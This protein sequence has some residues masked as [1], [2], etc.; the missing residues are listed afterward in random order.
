MTSLNKA[1]CPRQFVLIV[2][3]VG[4]V[5]FGAAAV[6]FALSFFIPAIGAAG[7]AHEDDRFRWHLEAGP[8]LWLNN[9]VT[10]GA[11]ASA[12][13][14]T[15]AKSE[16][17]YDDGYNR[18]DASGNL[19]DGTA[20][21]LASRTGYFGYASDKQVDLKAGTLALHL[22]R[23]SAGEY[24]TEKTSQ[25]QPAWHAN[26]RVSMRREEPT[27]REWGL[28]LGIDMSELKQKSSSAIDTN[29]QVLTDTY[30]LGGVV[31]QRAP[32]SGRFSPLPGDQRIG[33][34]AT[35]TFSNVTGTVTGQ[36]EF[37]ART[38]AL[39][40]G[41][42][43]EFGKALSGDDLPELQRWALGLRGGLALISTRAD[44]KVTEQVQAPGL[45]IGSASSATARRSRTDLGT[46][47]GATVRRAFTR[48]LALV[49]G[50]EFIRGG[51]LTLTQGNNFVR[52]DLSRTLVA[53]L[54]LEWAFDK[55]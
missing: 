33:D 17:Y 22:S 52:L 13:P 42:W 55:R 31:P 51:R 12:N 8:S 48:R 46:F 10:Y 27:A 5:V 32:Y 15:A 20:G 36:R 14:A 11:L 35:R 2:S 37:D 23:L 39:R 26:L 1:H 50:L 6:A 54:G 16:R 43:I 21:P 34:V 18:V 30:A 40:L 38:T 53:Q 47:F 41:P 45:P 4:S 19:G 49:G 9:R 7:A 3:G 29:I 44:F 24:L 28:E 25:K